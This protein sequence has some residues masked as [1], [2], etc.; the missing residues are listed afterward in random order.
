MK[1]KLIIFIFVC[2][3]ILNCF[4]FTRK[5]PK[6]YYNK[7]EIIENEFSYKIVIKS[8]KNTDDYELV[9]LYLSNTSTRLSSA[10]LDEVGILLKNEDEKSF[11]EITK[12]F[13]QH[14]NANIY[15]MV[16]YLYN[17]RKERL[18]CY[19]VLKK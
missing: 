12:E 16:F 1:K 7:T 15:D 9:E 2:V 10:Y 17:K 8:I 13:L 6:K 19:N 3:S 11:F 4:S 14:N 18:E 5:P